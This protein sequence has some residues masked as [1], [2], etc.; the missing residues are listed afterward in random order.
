MCMPSFAA[1][2]AERHHLPEV[3]RF[4]RGPG[5]RKRAN[6]P[7]DCIRHGQTASKCRWQCSTQFMQRQAFRT[8][9]HSNVHPNSRC[10]L[11]LCHFMPWQASRWNVRSL[12]REK[13]RLAA[14]W[15]LA[16]ITDT[17]MRE[18]YVSKAHLW[19]LPCSHRAH[20]R[21]MTVP[22]TWTLQCLQLWKQIF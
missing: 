17:G 7:S 10:P 22:R 14:A 6:F 16:S 8:S 12:T 19:L 9:T 13:K 2:E 21:F 20:T 5:P 18:R 11:V 15:L 4:L 1:Y 3:Q